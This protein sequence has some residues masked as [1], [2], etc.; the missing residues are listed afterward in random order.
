MDGIK[1]IWYVLDLMTHPSRIFLCFCDFFYQRLLTD[2]SS[3]IIDNVARCTATIM[4]SSCKLLRMCY[5]VTVLL[6]RAT[7]VP[8]LQWDLSVIVNKQRSY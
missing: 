3:L 2:N 8:A 4:T 1:D 6:L 5:S 7:A